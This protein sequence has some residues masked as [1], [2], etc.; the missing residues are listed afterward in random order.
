[1]WRNNRQSG[2]SANENEKISRKRR[3]PTQPIIKTA[4][5]YELHFGRKR[6]DGHCRHGLCYGDWQCDCACPGCS[7]LREQKTPDR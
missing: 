1:M 7:G 3:D 6:S 2:R 4:E 5:Y